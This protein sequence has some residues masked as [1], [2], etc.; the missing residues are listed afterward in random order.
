MPIVSDGAG[1][2][3]KSRQR[4]DVPAGVVVDHLDAIA[5]GVGNE[6]APAVGIEGGVIEVA[7]RGAWYGDGSDSFQRHDDLTPPC[8]PSDALTTIGERDKRKPALASST[9]NLLE[10]RVLRRAWTA[11]V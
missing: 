11:T 8:T 10:H 4:C 3:R 9:R 7:A 1:D 6:D 2:A 5:R